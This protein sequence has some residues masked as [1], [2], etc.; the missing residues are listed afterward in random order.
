MDGKL[1]VNEVEVELGHDELSNICC[2]LSESRKNE[3]IF[4]ELAKSPSEGVRESVAWKKHLTKKTARLL[5]NDASIEVLREIVGHGTAKGLI[6]ED[7]I[8]RLISLQ[9][10]AIMVTI[11]E[12]VYEYHNC[13][14]VFIYNALLN[15]ADPQ[16]R[17]QLAQDTDIPEIFLKRLMKDHDIE[18]S[19]EAKKTLEEIREEDE[20]DLEVTYGE[21]S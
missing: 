20:E 2:S 21:V 3:E 7:D 8:S 14:E 18:V 11:A 16:V 1:I 5:L 15:Q 19:E 12:N 4:H 9:D 6:T 10:T 17:Y 13:D